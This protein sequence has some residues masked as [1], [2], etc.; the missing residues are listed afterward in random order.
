LD[1]PTSGLDP[2]TE[3]NMMRLLRKLADQGRTIV[4][5]T[6]ATKNV[7]M[8]DKVIIIVRGGRLA[9]Y[10]PP[11]ESLTYFDRFRSDRERRTKDI[12][13]DD[14]Y[15]IL[16]DESRGTSEDWDKR[17]KKSA[18][19]ATYV[20]KRLQ[21]R[22]GATPGHSAPTGASAAG[23]RRTAGS[24]R[25]SSLRQFLILSVRNLR[26]MTQ[27]KASLALMLA[28]SPLIGVMDFM[29]GRDL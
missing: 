11:E 8:C 2:G 21:E 3:Y 20:V 28:L 13:F 9:Y 23:L 25:V 22:K 14:I 6:H 1:E 29:W 18:Q 16:E 17:Y 15:A 7:M 4:L 12:E 10:G 24:K 19:Y 27:D 26:I 5:I